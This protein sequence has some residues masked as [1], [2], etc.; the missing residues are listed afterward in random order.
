MILSTYLCSKICLLLNNLVPVGTTLRS[1]H[2]SHQFEA[3]Y[4]KKNY[5]IELCMVDKGFR[6]RQYQKTTLASNP[7]RDYKHSSNVP[8]MV[9]YKML[10]K[11]FLYCLEIYNCHHIFYSIFNFMCI[12]CRS[13]FVL[14]FFFF[15][16]L[17]CLFY[18]LQILWYLQT[19]LITYGKMKKKKKK[20]SET[21]NLIEPKLYIHSHW[22]VII[23]FCVDWKFKST[24]S[25]GHCLT[26]WT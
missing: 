4:L 10:C 5:W 13:L 14:L 20:F 7:K 16:S 11:W 1:R 6:R 12:F 9:L 15:W 18:D 21:I 17:C 2:N 23:I 26:M 19:L 22:I 3:G 8:C 25:T 24:D